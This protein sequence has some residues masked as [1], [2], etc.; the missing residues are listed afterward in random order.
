MVNLGE[1]LSVSKIVHHFQKT[2][3]NHKMIL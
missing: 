3:N 2:V 1:K